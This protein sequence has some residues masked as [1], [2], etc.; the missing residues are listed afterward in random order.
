MSSRT[1]QQPVARTRVG[2]ALASF[3]AASLIAI[4]LLGSLDAAGAAALPLGQVTEFSAGLNAHSRP[5]DLALGPDGNLWFTDDGL[6]QFGGRPAIGRITPAGQITE[7]SAGLNPEDSPYALAAGPEGS[8]WFTVVGPTP[9]IGRITPAGQ[10]TEYALTAGVFPTALTAGTDGNLWFTDSR[11]SE[12]DEDFGVYGVGPSCGIG[13]MTPSG[14]VMEFLETAGFPVSPNGLPLAFPLG[15]TAGADGN[16]WF[17][18]GSCS[19]GISIFRRQ[20]ATPA[21]EI[22]R[23]TPAGQITEFPAGP[24]YPD[25]ITA[26]AGG[27]LWFTD[28]RT[29][30]SGEEG[31]VAIGRITPSGQITTFSNGLSPKSIPGPYIGIPEIEAPGAHGITATAD[32]NVWFIDVGTASLGRITPSGKITEYP[33]GPHHEPQSIAQGSD[34]NLWFTDTHAMIG[35]MGAGRNIASP[36]LT[37]SLKQQLTPRGK[38]AKIGALLKSGGLTMPFRALEAGSLTVQWYELPGG[39]KQKKARPVLV[40]EGKLGFSGAGIGQLKLK[41]TNSGKHLLKTAKRVRLM[42][43]G[44][45]VGSGGASVNAASAVVVRQ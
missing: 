3:G 39:A 5:R 37:A 4:L 19:Q 31:Q 2:I 32:G 24:V 38:A 43:R 44:R 15:I 25:A 22:G 18:D 45:F 40:A 30:T 16:V 7:F 17:T 26:G 41:L 13:R 34:G 42:V 23:I 33:A 12:R 10:I 14:Q 1:I 6:P 36:Q 8:V 21:C 35:R 9:A 20:E 28:S 11:C 27:N 29:I